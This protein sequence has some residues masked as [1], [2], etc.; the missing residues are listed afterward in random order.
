MTPEEGDEGW[1]GGEVFFRAWT[2]GSALFPFPHR[3]SQKFQTGV[4][5]AAFPS[6]VVDKMQRKTIAR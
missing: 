5:V 6:Q 2:A 4:I 3:R 1:F